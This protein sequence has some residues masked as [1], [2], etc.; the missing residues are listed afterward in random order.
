MSTRHVAGVGS[1]T[2]QRRGGHCSPSAWASPPARASCKRL[3]LTLLRDSQS[4]PRGP[5]PPAPRT[6]ATMQRRSWTLSGATAAT[7]AAT[8]SCSRTCGQRR[9]RCGPPA[10]TPTAAARVLRSRVLHTAPRPAPR[11]SPGRAAPRVPAPA[12]CVFHSPSSRLRRT[13]PSCRVPPPPWP[14]LPQAD[15]LRGQIDSVKLHIDATQGLLRK[16][17]D[18]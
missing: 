11:R 7:Q 14:A 18:R 5:H 12:G 9:R 15:T 16:S 6:R 2:A 4:A 10:P 3:R 17:E 8:G 1:D 13:A